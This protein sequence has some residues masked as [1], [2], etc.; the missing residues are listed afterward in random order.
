MKT[1]VIGI[2]NKYTLY[3]KRIK[4]YFQGSCRDGNFLPVTRLQNQ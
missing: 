2:I 1:D 4:L 3:N